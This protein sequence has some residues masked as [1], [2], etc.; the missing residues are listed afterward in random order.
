MPTQLRV[1]SVTTPHGS[2]V[3]SS[4]QL[5]GDAGPVA[6]ILPLPTGAFV[7]QSSDAWFEALEASTAPRV[8]PPNGLSPTCPGDNAPE[9]PVDVT[10]SLAHKDSLLPQQIVVAGSAQDVSSWADTQGLSVPAELVSKLNS[11]GASSFFCALFQAPSG[12]SITPT[13]RVSAPTG[14]AVLPFSL[15]ASGSQALPVVAWTFAPTRVNFSGTVEQAISAG[16]LVWNA[17]DQ[18]SNYTEV[19]QDLLLEAT[20]NILPES[21]GH[22]TLTLPL[23]VPNS[24]ASLEALVPAYFERASAYGNAPSDPEPCVSSALVGFESD[25]TVSHACPRGD[26]AA[27]AGDCVLIAPQAGELNSTEFLCGPGADDLALVAAG[28]VGKNIWL[29]RHSFVLPANSTGEDRAVI[30]APKVAIDPVFTASAVDLADCFGGAGGGSTTSSTTTSSTTTSTSSS[31]STSTTG[32][33]SSTGSGN[34]TGFGGF[35]GYGGYA[36]DPYNDGDDVYIDTSGCACAGTV[37]TD[38]TYESSGDDCDSGSSSASSGDDCDSGSSG[39]DSYGSDDCDSGS[40]AGGDDCDSG[41]SA[42]GDSCDSG[43]SGGDSCDTGSSTEYGSDS[44]PAGGE[45]FNNANVSSACAVSR[46]RTPSARAKGPRLSA[47]T[48]ALLALVLP[49]RRR[50]SQKRRRDTPTS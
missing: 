32:A 14:F 38:S 17:K 36:G 10:S 24:Q 13:L 41:S 45:G 18:I 15:T 9:N 20:G 16:S 43:S 5:S 3:W 29:T 50:G 34:T 21:A 22:K 12:V 8:V 2:T 35:G 4:F 47:M 49:F 40:S 23:A 7:D 37:P 25:Q 28:T 39:G 6:I 27:L 44:A 46:A 33:G 26:L 1:A 42:G 30:A 11:T 19:R 48:L 31:S